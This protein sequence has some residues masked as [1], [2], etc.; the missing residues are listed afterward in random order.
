MARP[1]TPKLSAPAIA[2]AALALVDRNGE[3]TIPGLAKAMGVSPSSLYNHVASKDDIVEMM[4]GAAMGEIELPEPDGDWVNTLRQIATGYMRSYAKHP[5]LIPL[6]T[7]HTVRDEG[8]LRVYDRLAGAFAA[9][10]F[11][12]ADSLAAITVLDSFVLGSA[13]DAAAP[14]QVWES[15]DENS[16]ALN[17]ALEAGLAVPERAWRTFEY[18]LEILL[19]GFRL[20]GNSAQPQEPATS[21]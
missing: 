15:A 18:G 1:R 8:T 7:A 6:F 19:A 3:F 4:R 16:G 5:R 9:G 12:A 20:Q 10:G 21:S 13:L 17:A 11:T 14:S 2:D